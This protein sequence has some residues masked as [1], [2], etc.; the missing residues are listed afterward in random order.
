MTKK[1]DSA[2]FKRILKRI[3]TIKIQGAEN[4]CKAGVEAYLLQ[5]N[6][7]S[8]KKI[9]ATRPTEP[10]LQNAIKVLEKS[11]FKI[12]TAKKFLTDLKKSHDKIAKLGSRLIKNEMNIYSHCH[13]STVM[14]I[15]KYAKKK[16]KK[17]F[18]VYTSEV[19]PLLQGRITAKDLAK[20]K[21]KTVVVPDLAAE[22]TLEK[23]DIFFFGAD[24]YTSS[25]VANKL[26]TSTLVNHAKLHRIPRYSC[27]VSLKFTK[28]ITIQNRNPSEVWK[29]KNPF[30]KVENQPFDKTPLKNLTGII[31]EHGILKQKRFVKAAKQ[32]LRAL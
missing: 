32:K 23:C 20:S 30:I 17:K 31:S 3:E 21:I 27:G 15:L 5:P 29:I 18:T 13:S 19:E 12:R 26:G 8:A 4:V 14:D 10:L 11:K 28:K 25:K 6:P 24:A 16:Q 7:E 1:G 2:K 22:H 9:L